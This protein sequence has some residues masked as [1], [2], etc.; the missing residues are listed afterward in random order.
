[1]RNGGKFQVSSFQFS[2]RR[3]DDSVAAGG[4]GI[5]VGQQL[6]EG[7]GKIAGMDTKFFE[8]EIGTGFTF[9]G[10]DFIKT[11]SD[12]AVDG[13]GIE[14]AFMGETVVDGGGRD[15]AQVSSES[16]GA[17]GFGRSVLTQR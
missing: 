9:C 8:I 6:R 12:L 1:V 17:A 3:D 10:L 11:A 16:R 13:E 4:A 2:A 5:W 15:V 14:H 7:V